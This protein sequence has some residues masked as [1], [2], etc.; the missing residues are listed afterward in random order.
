M[1]IKIKKYISVFIVIVFFIS[2]F[3]SIHMFLNYIQH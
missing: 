1:N 2:I 3:K